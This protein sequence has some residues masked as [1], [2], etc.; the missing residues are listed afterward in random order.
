MDKS[1]P[2]CGIT[3]VEY[4]LNGRHLL[5]G[6]TVNIEK[7]KIYVV[8]GG[9]GS[10]KTTL[11]EIL[12]GRKRPTAGEVRYFPDPPVTGYLSFEEQEA[13]LARERKRDE[14]WLG[15]GEID[16]GSTGAELIGVGGPVSGTP[17]SEGQ[18]RNRL[19]RDIEEYVRLLRIRDL[20]RRG[21]RQFSTGEFRKVLLCRELA[22]GPALLLLD[23]PCDGLD[24]DSRKHVR[25]FIPLWREQGGTVVLFLHR[26]RDVPDYADCVLYLYNG[27][28]HENPPPPRD[29]HELG[30]LIDKR[31]GGIE[32]PIRMRD[33][34]VS[35]QG[36]PVLKG[37]TW[38]AKKRETWMITGPNGSGKS[39]LLSLINGDNPKAYGQEIYLFG[40]KRGSGESVWDIK[41]RIGF[42]SGDLQFRYFIRSSAEEVVLSGLYDSIGLYTKVGEHER[43]TA[44]R[45]L[46][47]IGLGKKREEPFQSLSF[48][49][50]RMV[51]LIRAVI[52]GPEI[53]LADEPCQGLDDVNREDVLR[54]LEVIAANGESLLLYVTHEPEEYLR[55]PYRHMRLEPHPAG[56]FTNRFV[57]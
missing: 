10:G 36:K 47:E 53:L 9:N 12:A 38:E 25:D 50:Q 41:K 42:V 43:Q 3:E 37:I 20:L 7:G 23:E 39:T 55:V 54:A 52:K 21:C 44:V 51:L 6:L 15:H 46:K 5:K 34:S 18:P 48:G 35:Y 26:S 17:A 40:R 1:A 24:D 33:V 31:V 29:H 49:Q 2:L 45:W 4:S 30:R 19:P 22:K 56:G 13:V 28:L 11:A 57:T 14:T 32:T 8:V 16:Y 27:G